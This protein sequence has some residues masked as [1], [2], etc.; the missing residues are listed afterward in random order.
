MLLL[1]LLAP[2]LVLSHGSPIPRDALKQTP[3]IWQAAMTGIQQ[4]HPLRHGTYAPMHTHKKVQAQTSVIQGKPDHLS[5][6]SVEPAF[7]TAAAESNGFFTDIRNQDWMRMK[8]RPMLKGRGHE[9]SRPQAW[10]Q[11]NWEPSFTCQH[12]R[13]IGG[14]GD[15]P[16]WVCD[17]HRIDPDSCLI[18]SFGSNN[19]FS[20]EESVLREISAK[21]EIHTFDPTIGPTPS[22]ESSLT[23]LQ[24]L[25][26]FWPMGDS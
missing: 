14:N 20:F 16:K 8:S 11:D 15:G 23:Q 7:A 2:L 25:S 13:R 9:P 10:F 26:H 6:K 24:Q 18:Y 12:E 1:L 3:P 5:Y 17:P 21:C 4:E 22:S 19:D